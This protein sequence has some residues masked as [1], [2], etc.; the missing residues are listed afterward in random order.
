MEPRAD[1]QDV[2]A[3]VSRALQL[4]YLR[5]ARAVMPD[6]PAVLRYVRGTSF[7]YRIRFSLDHLDGSVTGRRALQS[8]HLYR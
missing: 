5:E 8:H 3:A 1:G 7:Q 2:S 6:V 4:L